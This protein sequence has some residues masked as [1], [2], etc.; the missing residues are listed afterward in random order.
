MQ[1]S[2]QTTYRL[3]AMSAHRYINVNTQ[4]LSPPYIVFALHMSD[5]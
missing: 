1:Y 4:F 2:M 5:K 3:C